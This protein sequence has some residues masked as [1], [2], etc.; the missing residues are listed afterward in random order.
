MTEK[1]HRREF[2]KMA[3]AGSAAAGSK[4]LASSFGLSDE[5]ADKPKTF[6]EPFDYEGIA[7]SD[8][9]LKKQFDTARD[10]FHAIPNDDILRGFRIRAGLPAPGKDLG[11]WYSGDPSTIAWWSSGDIFH[12]F[13]QWLSGMARMSRATNDTALREKATYLMQEWAKTIGPDGY[14]FYSKRPNAPHYIYEKTMCG[15][16]DMY[17]YAGQKDAVTWLEKITDWAITNLDRSRKPDS[18]TE[19]YTLSENLYRAYLLTCNVKYKSFGDV[20]RHTEYWKTFTGGS[21]LARY[22]HHAYSHVNTL[23]SA[24]MTYAV[25]GD[26]EYLTTIVNA[27]D[28]LERTQFYATGGYGPDERLLPAMAR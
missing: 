19:W 1:S 27:Y 25:T 12:V 10:Y 18:G 24:A 4:A 23:S 6:L 11:G 17:Q 13:G 14:F 5:A 26:Q 9:R 3:L 8:C 20:W 21:S 16:V 22:G 15:L 28:W 2:L 7:L